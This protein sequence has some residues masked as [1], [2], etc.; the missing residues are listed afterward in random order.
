[1]KDHSEAKN[2]LEQLRDIIDGLETRAMNEFNESVCR[3]D[4]KL[5]IIH[6]LKG[7]II[8]TNRELEKQIEREKKEQE[9]G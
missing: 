7:V 8:G 1:M 2:I 3:K 5:E 4:A 9:Q 6:D